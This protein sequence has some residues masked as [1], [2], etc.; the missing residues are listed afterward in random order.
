VRRIV[1]DP[2]LRS[3]LDEYERFIW[4]KAKKLARTY[5]DRKDF[6]QVGRE[7]VVKV[8]KAMEGA[9]K[10]RS[11]KGY[12][13]NSIENAM[14]D[15][16]RR[17]YRRNYEVWVYDKKNGPTRVK[18]YRYGGEWKARIQYH[19]DKLKRVVLG[20]RVHLRYEEYFSYDG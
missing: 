11:E 8:F 12:Y 14:L 1:R 15:Y 9:L 4:W 7:A 16:Y 18:R 5:E 17:Q 19:G 20:H 3:T 13:L 2:K 6:E 10:V